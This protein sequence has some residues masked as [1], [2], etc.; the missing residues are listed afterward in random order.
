MSDHEMLDL[1]PL[2]ALMPSMARSTATSSPTSR[3]VPSA[4]RP[5]TNITR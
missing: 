4:S 5:S 2:Y 1:V 3:P